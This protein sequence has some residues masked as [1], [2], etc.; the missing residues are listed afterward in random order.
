LRTKLQEKGYGVG[1]GDEGGFAPEGF[2]TRK[3]LEF[4]IS[5]IEAAGYVPGKDAFLGMDVAAGS[6]YDKKSLKYEIKEE[7]LSLSALEM[8][9]Y[10]SSLLK[11]FPII[12]LEDPLYEDALDDWYGLYKALSK[13][14]MIVGDDLVVTNSSILKKALDPK[15]LNA[16]IVKP[17]QIGTLSETLEF[18]R[19]AQNNDLVTIVSHR[20]GDTAEDTFVSDL[21]LGTGA[22]FVKFGAPARGERVVKYNRLLDLYH[23]I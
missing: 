9:S 12:Y 2:T 14:T 6:F 15:C 8:S 4:L 22:E 11:D 16:V 17:N 10:Y 19:L 5:S 23:R 21:A 7:S 1:L 18:M 3:A 13:R 20:S